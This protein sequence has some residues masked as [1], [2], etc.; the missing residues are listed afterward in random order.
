ML[1][2]GPMYSF[3]SGKLFQVPCRTQQHS[4]SLSQLWYRSREGKKKKKKSAIVPF[5]SCSRFPNRNR[6]SRDWERNQILQSRREEIRRVNERWSFVTRVEWQ[7]AA[8]RGFLEQRLEYPQTM[9][10]GLGLHWFPIPRPVFPSCLSPSDGGMETTSS[11]GPIA[12]GR[13]D[14]A[15][16]IELATMK[17]N[18]E[19]RRFQRENVGC[20]DTA[21]S[22][23][24]CEWCTSTQ[25]DPI[26]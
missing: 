26:R 6:N 10:L 21:Q 9:V 17:L 25:N 15:V 8:A 20:V 24:C 19:A 2:V 22:L 18:D 3:N 13:I 16:S 5:G 1:T 4:D 23:C 14:R 12:F 11:P 7:G